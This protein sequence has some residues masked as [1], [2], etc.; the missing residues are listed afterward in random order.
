VSRAHVLDPTH[1]AFGRKTVWT[2]P[3][4]ADRCM[5][6]KNDNEIVCLS[7]AKG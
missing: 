6:V 5:I 7:L 4:F 1:A 2:H 3:S